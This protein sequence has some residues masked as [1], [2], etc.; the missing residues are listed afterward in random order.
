MN[1][2]QVIDERTGQVSTFCVL[3]TDENGSVWTVPQGHRFWDL[4]QEWLATGNTPLPAA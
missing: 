1:F 2:Q 4:Y 3:Y